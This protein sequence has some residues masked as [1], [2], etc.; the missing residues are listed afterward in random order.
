M[1]VFRIGDMAAHRWQLQF[2]VPRLSDVH[3]TTME[4]Y[5]FSAYWFSEDLV[6]QWTIA[7]L[8]HVSPKYVCVCWYP[9]TRIVLD[10]LPFFATLLWITYG[11]LSCL[12]D[13]F[14]CVPLFHS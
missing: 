14:V 10:I 5:G 12:Q 7:E 6:R 9:G 11:R 8:I 4:L 2:Q 1:Q 3:V 13:I